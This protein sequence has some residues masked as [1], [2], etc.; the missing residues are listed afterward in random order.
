MSWGEGVE[1]KL[2]L[3]IGK[4]VERNRTKEK[5]TKFLLK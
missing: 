5:I 1:A 3:I 2:K 4:L